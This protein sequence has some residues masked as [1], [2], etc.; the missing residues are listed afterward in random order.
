MWIN[1]VTPL[2]KSFGWSIA[3]INILKIVNPN[4]E[5]VYPITSAPRKAATGFIMKFSRSST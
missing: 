4:L 1:V 2:K 3:P 5:M